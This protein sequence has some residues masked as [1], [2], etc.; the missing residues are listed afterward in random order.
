MKTDPILTSH[1]QMVS[2]C[3]PVDCVSMQNKNSQQIILHHSRLRYNYAT[4][5]RR[6]EKKKKKK[7]DVIKARYLN[8]L[9]PFKGHHAVTTKLRLPYMPP[10]PPFFF[11]FFFNNN[12][13]SASP[14]PFNT[15]FVCETAGVVGFQSWD[16]G[17]LFQIRHCLYLFRHDEFISVY[18]SSFE[19]RCKITR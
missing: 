2:N 6:I 14:L 11:F 19:T 16:C 18:L 12:T 15:E 10:P 13:R 3:F 9:L 8:R 17:F 1:R 4:R 7:G 5:N